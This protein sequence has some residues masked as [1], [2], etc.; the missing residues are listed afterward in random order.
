MH[1]VS[2]I[3]TYFRKEL[4]A[5]FRDREIVNWAYLSIDHFLGYNR[6]D[7]IVYA[8]ECIDIEVVDK[9]KDVVDDLKSNKPIQYILGKTDFY[10]L[11]IVVN[12]DVLIPRPET[13]E[14]V[15][16]AL[17]E[18]FNSALDIGTGSGCIAIA[19]AKH[20]DAIISAIDISKY[21]LRLARENMMLNNVNINLIQQD[22][23]E[24]RS[25]DKVDLIISN[26]PYVLDSEKR[27]MQKNILD[28]EPHI[29][30]FVS[31]DDPLVFYKHIIN[32]ATES[33]FSGGRLFFEIN[34][35]FADKVISILEKAG[36]VD[37]ELKKDIN[38]KDRMVKGIWK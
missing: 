24:N 7:C 27:Y 15:D 9:L 1:K 2:N 10:G 3:M 12:S 23:F 20:S 36:F 37:I 38:D 14:L 33:L 28:F 13:E 6:A 30:L 17:E 21:V 26:P 5:I 8:N 25:I 34:E 31:D 22:I 18:D 16:W 19:L 11:Q 4:G 35:K 32:M 29:A